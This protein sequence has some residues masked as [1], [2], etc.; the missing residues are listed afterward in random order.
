MEGTVRALLV[1]L[2]APPI[3][4]FPDWGA[5]ID[6]SRPFRLRCDAS[7]AGLG[8]TLE[9]K[10]P[11]G[12]IRPIVYISRAT[13]D[14]EQNLTPMELEAGC[15]VSSIRR[16]RR[17]LFGVYFLV[18]IN[19]QCLQQI[20]KIGETK[21]RIQRWMEF[22]SAYNFRLSYRRGQGNANADFLS[23]LPLPPIAEDISDASALTDPDLASTSS[24]RA[25][26]A[27][28]PAPS[29]AWAWVG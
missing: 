7:T 6:T 20:C 5:V 2:A 4:V 10:Q 25:G 19:H 15:V 23:R 28:P 22:L 11:D 8:A 24:M 14:N 21:P 29:L 16:L 17:Y 9:Q 1:E 26:L 3:L 18:L 12:S 13:L 27:P